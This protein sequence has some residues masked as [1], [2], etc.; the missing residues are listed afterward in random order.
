M[1]QFPGLEASALGN[2]PVTPKSMQGITQPH[3]GL[4]FICPSVVG[5]MWLV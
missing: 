3:S 1:N 2:N 4:T 5:V